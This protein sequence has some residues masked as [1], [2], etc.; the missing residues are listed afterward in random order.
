[1]RR[2]FLVAGAIAWALAGCGD[3]TTSSPTGS[4]DLSVTTAGTENDPDGFAILV[5]DLQRKVLPGAGRAVIAGL[6]PGTHTVELSGIAPNC[7]VT[8][9]NPLTIEIEAGASTSVTFAVRCSPPAASTGA[10]RLAI[11]TTGASLDLSGYGVW[12][13]GTLAGLAALQD[14][15]V[16]T[17]L[18]GGDHS[19]ELRDNAIACAAT[20]GPIVT[21]A[22]T[23]PDTTTVT[24]SVICTMP[25]P[26][27]T[28]IGVSVTTQVVNA[29][30][31]SRYTVTLDG[32][33]SKTVPSNGGVSFLTTP[34]THSILLRGTP[35]YCG[36]GGFGPASNPQMIIVFA[37]ANAFV[38]FDVLCIG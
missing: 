5:D 21:V 22:V 16:V 30:L 34:G 17:G 28:T 26:P 6:E 8:T 38:H 3:T 23:P 29:A 2:R 18:A 1:M 15:V 9:D 24:L 27:P 13:D 36:V 14:T 25:A 19:V 31:P 35:P 11:S 33:Q 32:R 4:L 7:D 12:V 10:I 20:G 37:G